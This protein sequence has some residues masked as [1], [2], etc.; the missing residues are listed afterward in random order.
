MLGAPNRGG[1]H[2]V[3]P[4]LMAA[5]PDMFVRF[6][7]TAF[8]AE[9][10]YR[11]TGGGGGDHIELQVGDSRIMVGGGGPVEED[12]PAALFLYVDE[13]DGLHDRALQAGAT[14]IMEPA[15]GRFGEERGAGLVGADRSQR[16]S[17]SR[18]QAQVEIA[19]EHLGQAL[20]L[21]V[22]GG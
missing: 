20:R 10:T 4:Y 18:R 17:R 22:R 15:D 21:G 7:E 16:W 6:L 14:S 8:G 11:T 12:R 2:T 19:G 1:F 9:V 5:D 13:V 3:T